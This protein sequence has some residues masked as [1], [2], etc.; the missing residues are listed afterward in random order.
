MVSVKP[1]AHKVRL[2][3]FLLIYHEFRG[4]VWE[5]LLFLPEEIFSA[6]YF[7]LLELLYFSVYAFFLISSIYFECLYQ[8][9]I[10]KYQKKAH[11][12]PNISIHFLITFFF[13]E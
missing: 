9:F 3:A 4:G 5:L 6:Y 2:A 10:S 8:T 7:F 11:C 12:F 1:I 13:P